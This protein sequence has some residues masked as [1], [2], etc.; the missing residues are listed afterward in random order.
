[1]SYFKG[2]ID[3]N[4]IKKTYRKLAL[5]YHP[6]K[7]GDNNKMQEVNNQY[8]ELKKNF[9]RFPSSLREVQL[10][11]FVYVNESTCIVIDVDHKHFMAKSLKTKR[12]AFIDKETGY[13]L[14]N[15]KIK[16]KLN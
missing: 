7:G 3:R 13:G 6:D 5:K 14:F 4:E 8:F 15:F 9:G 16:A 11:N 10:G 1:M 2:I 12:E